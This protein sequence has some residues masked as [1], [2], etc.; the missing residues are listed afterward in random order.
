[1][2]K[3]FLTLGRGHEVSGSIE[4]LGRLQ[5]MICRG[6]APADLHVL[7]SRTV[8]KNDACGDNANVVVY[9]DEAGV[10]QTVQ[11]PVPALDIAR[12]WCAANPA[13]ADMCA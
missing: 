11:G 4:A 12:A 8:L 10:P 1:M 13:I 6:T 2:S 9:H 3:A 5:K 7:Q